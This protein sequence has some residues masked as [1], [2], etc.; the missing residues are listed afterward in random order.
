M[1]DGA[2]WAYIS[3]EKHGGRAGSFLR[4]EDEYLAVFRESNRSSE[5]CFAFA[6]V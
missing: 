1:V 2:K 3:G 5:G 4:L 6:V